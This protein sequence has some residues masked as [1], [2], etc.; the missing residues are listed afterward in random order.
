[1]EHELKSAMFAEVSEEYA[2]RVVDA[3]M[4]PD[5]RRYVEPKPFLFAFG[6]LAFGVLVAATIAVWRDVRV[7][8]TK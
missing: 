2:L 5:R 3:A 8:V 7:P 6:A 1:M 4:V